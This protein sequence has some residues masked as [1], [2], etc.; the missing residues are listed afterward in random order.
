MVRATKNGA[1]LLLGSSCKA[2]SEC[3]CASAKF[4][5]RYARAASFSSFL[6]SI[7]E[8]DCDARL[9]STRSCAAVES[10]KV[11]TKNSARKI[12]LIEYTVT[13]WLGAIR[14]AKFLTA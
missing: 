8:D 2:R 3:D 1:A 11:L 5:S 10:T 9:V 4:P 7:W 13:Q 14:R 12:T 6:A